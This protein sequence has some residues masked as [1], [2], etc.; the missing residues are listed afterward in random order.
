MQKIQ[1]SYEKEIGAK[2]NEVSML[3]EHLKSVHSIQ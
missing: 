2:S 3:R 1:E